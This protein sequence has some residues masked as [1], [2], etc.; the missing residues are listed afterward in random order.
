MRALSA[1]ELLEVW[2]HGL[3]QSPAQ[4]ALALLAIACTEIPLN[5]ITQLTIGQRDTR[6]LAL[7]KQTFGPQLASLAICPACREHHSDSTRDINRLASLSAEGRSS[8]TTIIIAAILRWMSGAEADLTT[9][10]QG[11]SIPLCNVFADTYP[12]AEIILL[13]VEEPLAL[14]HAP[15]ESVDPS[16]IERLALSLALFLRS[17][18]TAGG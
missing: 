6:L 2:E 16:E 3:G 13:G 1:A 15:N 11:G 5:Q 9:L 17:Y 18:G 14:I 12:R 10:G 8:A 7:R 4:R